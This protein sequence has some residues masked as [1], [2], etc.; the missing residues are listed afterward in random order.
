MMKK[1]LTSL[2]ICSVLSTAQ[3]Q[4][5]QFLGEYTADGTPTYFDGKDHVSKETLQRISDALPEGYPVPEYNPQY[6]TSG[7]DTNI[8]LQEAADIWVTFVGEGAGYKNVLGFYTYD[9]E[10]PPTQVPQPEAIT[11][12]FPNVSAKYSGGSLETGDKVKIGR[13]EAGT[14]I[15]WVLLANGWKGEVT[16]G[17]WQLFSDEKFNPEA[18]EELRCHNVLLSDPDNERIILGFEDIRRDYGSCDNDF[19]DALFYI[20][21]NPFSSIRTTNYSKIT[22]HTPVS[23]GNDGGLESNGDLARLIAQR[24]FTRTTSRNV[25][26]K[27]SLQYKYSP[28]QY[29][30]LKANSGRLDHYFPV[31]GMFG[32]ETPY[33][34]SPVDLLDITNAESVFSVDYYRNGERVSAALGTKTNGNV[35]NH[36]KTICDRL[37]NSKLQ[38]VRTV[39]LQGYHM[40]YSELLRAD[41]ATEYALVFSV[42]EEGQRR[43]VYSRWNL[44][45]Y[46]GGRYLN[47]QIWGNS[48]GQ[49]STIANTILNELSKETELNTDG[50][51]PT[52]PEV[53]VKNG[54]YRNGKL[55]LT[56][57]N[58]KH[59]SEVTVQMSYKTTEQS[60]LETSS[61]TISLSG[62]WE[63]ELVI[64]SGHV[65]D[66]GISVRTKV[67]NQY[68][69]MYVADGPWG[70]DMNTA[71]DDVAEFLI[72]PQY[73]VLENAHTIERGVR[74]K[75]KIKETINVFRNVLPGDLQLAVNSYQYLHFTLKNDRPVEVSLV[76][77]A[78]EEWSERLRL[79]LPVHSEATEYT[80]AFT[81]FVNH[82]GKTVDF[83]HLRT[84]VFSVQGDYRR[85]VPFELHIQQLALTEAGILSSDNGETLSTRHGQTEDENSTLKELRSFPNPFATS[86]TIS[87]PVP[88]ATVLV[89]ITDLKGQVVYEQK[90]ITQI[91]DQQ[92]RIEAPYLP[93]G[94]Y[95]YYLKDLQN[96]WIY[97][98]KLVKNDSSF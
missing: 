9:I 52:L 58:K 21:A 67:S 44:D 25:N 94:L 62:S 93:G 95:L 36:T 98:G 66:M 81:D 30:T 64:D 51:V 23:S 19:N 65:F 39:V 32:D 76:T 70:A 97:T 43:T 20:T 79:T 11:I 72:T 89:H 49:V 82:E 60:E 92:V 28:L 56:I 50:T 90:H 22:D 10:N 84:L 63:E 75:G 71:V 6:I 14:G 45:D 68:D 74:A 15:G 96:D 59:T 78:T 88:T 73:E 48:M 16:P 18:R 69:T 35:Y 1:L 87:L 34:S 4:N 13:F 31:S 55:Y 8:N 91:N 85:Y 26:N 40:I 77:E 3:S 47:F 57:V 7:Y 24:N 37:N 41:G 80:L 5:Y 29:K 61:Q 12:V 54:F 83:S 27:R 86:T 2:A 46:P 42:R 53:V 33:V 17:L 38:D